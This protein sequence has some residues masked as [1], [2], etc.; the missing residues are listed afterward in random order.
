MRKLLPF[1]VLSFVLAAGALAGESAIAAGPPAPAP[2]PKPAPAPAPA[3]TSSN[4]NV[5]GIYTTQHRIRFSDNLYVWVACVLADGETPSDIS[6]VLSAITGAAATVASGGT[7]ALLLTKLNTFYTA[8]QPILQLIALKPGQ[9]Y[10][11]HIKFKDDTETTLNFVPQLGTLA[12][13]PTTVQSAT[14][15]YIKRYTAAGMDNSTFVMNDNVN[16][17][18][19]PLC[20]HNS[21]PCRGQVFSYSSLNT[22]TSTNDP[23]VAASVCIEFPAASP[24]TS[25]I[26]GFGALD[27]I[28]NTSE[29]PTNDNPAPLSPDYSYINA[30]PQ[31]CAQRGFMPS[32]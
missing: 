10:C 17:L 2:A 4:T 31:S 22:Q 7:A 5:G 23:V 32:N 30:V 25:F 16:V 28:T 14:N 27:K 6:S 8:F 24:T 20:G 11:Y 12:A 3:P 13:D 9:A 15:S 18:E 1:I 26:M 29:Q 19:Y 21:C